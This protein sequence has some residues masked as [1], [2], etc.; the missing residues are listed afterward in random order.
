VPPGDKPVV[1][2][3]RFSVKRPVQQVGPL[4]MKACTYDES[5]IE[6]FGLRDAEAERTL[7]GQGLEVRR[8]PV[9]SPDE[10]SEA[11][12]CETG[13]EGHFTQG[14]DTSF[15]EL[16]TISRGGWLQADGAA[17]PENAVGFAIDTYDLRTGKALDAK[18]VFARPPGPMVLRCVTKSQADPQLGPDFWEPYFS[19]PRFDLTETG[20]HFYAVSYP[21]FAAVFTGQGP[22]IGYDV[23][24]RGGYLRPD[25]PAR[26][27]W[28]SVTPAPKTKDACPAGQDAWK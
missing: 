6:L 14:L 17:H 28:A 15:R 1:A 20:V 8:G 9:L 19:D 27:A 25:S 18:A 7:N 16:A 12:G 2:T 23:L 5:W 10:A 21:H 3:H 11:Q 4:G 22:V 13:F 26:R 24:L